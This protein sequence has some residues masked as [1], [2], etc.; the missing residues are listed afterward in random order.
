M[1]LCM[2]KH[3]ITRQEGYFEPFLSQTVF[4]S[5]IGYVN[6]LYLNRID[7]NLSPEM[8][9]C[10][11]DKWIEGR[12]RLFG[13]GLCTGGAQ[14]LKQRYVGQECYFLRGC[15]GQIHNP[16]TGQSRYYESTDRWQ[17]DSIFTIEIN[18]RKNTP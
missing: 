16:H 7:H 17:I 1:I 6:L 11:I 2:G 13:A 8:I 12:R 9:L 5:R 14:C 10:K 4:Q 18:Y 15:H 3:N